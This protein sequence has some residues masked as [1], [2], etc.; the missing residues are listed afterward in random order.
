MRTL[1]LLALLTFTI[2]AVSQ[3]VPRKISYQGIL[4][5]SSNG[6]PLADDEYF[7]QFSFFAPGNTTHVFQTGFVPVTTF[8]G[9]FTT[10][11][12]LQAMNPSLW[13]NQ[14]TM[15]VNV[16]GITPSPTVELTS[17]P[18]SF[19][20]GSAYT[21]NAAGLTGTVPNTTL[22]EDLQDLADGNLSGTK[23]GT[24]IPGGNVGTGIKASNIT[25]NSSGTIAVPML[26]QDLQDL[27]TGTLN[28]ALVPSGIDGA[29]ISAGI[30]AANITVGLL[31]EARISAIAGEKIGVGIKAA[32]ITDNT[33]GTIIPTMLPTAVQNLIAGTLDPALLPTGIDGSKIASGIAAE[34]ISSGI[35]SD[36]RLSTHLQDLADGTLSPELIGTGIDATKITTG[37]LNEAL[38]TNI[39]GSKVTTG[40]NAANISIGVL[41]NARLDSDLQDLADGSLSPALI[42]TG[43]DAT[44]IT[45]GTL[46]DAR[47][48]T[49]SGSKI[50]SGIDATN[51]SAGTL[52]ADLIGTGI[53]AG[54]ITVGTISEDRI[55]SISGAK[56]SDG[57]KASNITDAS[58]GLIDNAML[59]EDLQDL[60]DGTL[61]G[62]KIGSGIKAGNIEAGTLNIARLPTTVIRGTGTTNQIATFTS[63]NE[64][65]A[66][67]NLYWE[68][69]QNKLGINTLSPLAKLHIHQTGVT[70][71]I[72]SKAVQIRNQSNGTGK[73]L[74]IEIEV[75]PTTT[76][77]ITG[78]RNTITS[79]SSGT[80]YGINNTVAGTSAS[81]HYGIRNEATGP[82]ITYGIHSTTNGTGTSNYGVYS[83]ANGAS[84]NFSFYGVGKMQINGDVQVNGNLSYSGGLANSS[85]RKLK[86]NI[87]PVVSALTKIQKLKPS[88]YLFRIDEFPTLNLSRGIQFGLIAQEVEEILP[89]LVREATVDLGAN[90][91]ANVT[92]QTLSYKT[93]DYVSLIPLLIKGMQEQQEMIESQKL[94]IQILTT[95]VNNLKSSTAVSTGLN[96]SSK[97]D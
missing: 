44:K 73:K 21:M 43:I 53:D 5:N 49:I 3:D 17:T 93:V 20:A 89:N 22:D 77:E 81:I 72:D 48:A 32:N 2:N 30:D 64:I 78:I 40:I 23:I 71:G 47:I 12:D 42:G 1:V 65:A 54:K 59:D 9:L 94:A 68:N 80:A 97:K 37:I 46:S 4:V 50:T 66:N 92:E 96:A 75:A 45:L 87:Q 56:I 67:T 55:T 25:D 39:S 74:G 34:N 38:I 11:I 14:L 35:L 90:A 83:F 26:P 91:R 85:D 31:S 88:T 79:F 7:I 52:D 60:A 76:G 86:T 6:E 61:D 28:P 13:S 15:V 84:N 51:I 58:G 82:G 27:V 10:V 24:G 33:E 8:K 95:E 70:S 16:S 62:A 57:I 18:Y 63:A 29:K 69:T 41:D 19:I 36:A